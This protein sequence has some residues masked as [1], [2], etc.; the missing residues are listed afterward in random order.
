VL[1]LERGAGRVSVLQGLPAGTARQALALA[2]GHAGAGHRLLVREW[3]GELILESAAASLV[4]EAGFRRE[5]LDYVWA[6]G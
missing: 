3:N 6:G 1:L 4:E 5:M 2:A